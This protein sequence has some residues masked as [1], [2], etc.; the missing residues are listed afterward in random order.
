M[1]QTQPVRIREGT[2]SKY[3]ISQGVKLEADTSEHINQSKHLRGICLTGTWDTS[4]CPAAGTAH[5]HVPLNSGRGGLDLFKVTTLKSS[6][7]STG[8]W[9]FWCSSNSP[10]LKDKSSIENQMFRNTTCPDAKEGSKDQPG[11]TFRHCKQDGLESVQKSGKTIQRGNDWELGGLIW[12]SLGP[13]P[14]KA[15][16]PVENAGGF[17]RRGCRVRE[18]FC[19][20]P[21]SVLENFTT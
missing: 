19:C 3:L 4:F 12:M 21:V 6:R 8:L 15:G 5:G 10:S 14:Q 18:R 16:V 9:T 17:Q 13:A 2:V 20:F 7:T 11:Q 1:F